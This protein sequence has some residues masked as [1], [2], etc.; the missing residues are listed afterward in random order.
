MIDRIY[1]KVR[2]LSEEKPT[3]HDW[4][5]HLNVSDLE[6]IRKLIMLLRCTE[7]AFV[8]EDYGNSIKV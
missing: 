5:H 2:W 8:L 4:Q 7:D 3:L 1:L 6:R